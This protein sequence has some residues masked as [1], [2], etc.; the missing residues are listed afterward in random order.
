MT[1]AELKAQQVLEQAG[2]RKAPIPVEELPARYGVRVRS[3][4]FDGD[5]SGMLFRDQDGKHAVIGVN[6]KHSSHRQRFTV[7]HELGHYLLHRGRP[8]IVDKTV[9]VNRRDQTSS[10]ATDREEI[11]AN[12]FAAELLMPRKLVE[13]ESR[14]I[15]KASPV[16]TDHELVNGLAAEFDV[17]TQAMEYRLVNLGLLSPMV[18][19]SG[20]SL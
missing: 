3:E 13:S 7:A 16:T 11:E 10:M 18:A 20:T 9:R 12:A 6:A 4:P 14:K 1:R 15:L 19:G 2:L 5:I 8:M 17:S